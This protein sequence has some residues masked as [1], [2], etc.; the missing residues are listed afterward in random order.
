M[1]L[2]VFGPPGAGKGTL[3]SRLASELRIAQIATGDMIR[4]EIKQNTELG[5]NIASYANKGELVPDEI[6]IEALKKRLGQPD[7]HKGFVLDGYPRTLEQAKALERITKID[8]IIRIKIPES[9]LV[10]R[11]ANRIICRECGAVYNLKYLKPKKAG[12]CDVCGGELYQR[13]D[14]KPDVIRE[15]FRVYEMDT[16]PIMEYYKGKIPFVDVRYRSIK[17]PPEVMIERILQGLRKLGIMK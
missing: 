1:R 5:R 3:S 17:T 11:L 7:S 4:E 16:Q 2:I 12:V 15:R 10:E 13:E 8:A 14:D 6:I 9:M